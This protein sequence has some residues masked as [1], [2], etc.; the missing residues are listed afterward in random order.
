MPATRYSLFPSTAV[1]A[2]GTGGAKTYWA[3]ISAHLAEAMFETGATL[4]AG[5]TRDMFGDHYRVSYTVVNANTTAAPTTAAPTTVAA[6]SAA[7]TT[8]ATTAPPT[9]APPTSAAPTTAP[10]DAGFTFSV[11][12]VA[13]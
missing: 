13:I 9:T 1:T 11:A 8:A 5:S 7:P 3:K 12:A 10:P 6:T 4:A 2:S